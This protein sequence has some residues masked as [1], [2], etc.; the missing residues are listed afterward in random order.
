VLASDFLFSR[1]DVEPAIHSMSPARPLTSHAAWAEVHHD[2]TRFI[3]PF[4][5]KT[6][7][8]PGAE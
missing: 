5:R 6:K 8:K 1:L 2:F 3:A 4:Q 7:R